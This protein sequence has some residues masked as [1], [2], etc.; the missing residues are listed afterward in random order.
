MAEGL[1]GN[2]GQA[3][4]AGFASRSFRSLI[5]QRGDAAEAELFHSDSQLE[6]DQRSSLLDWIAESAQRIAF[7]A[8]R[9]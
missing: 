8:V 1:R 2:G 4:G 5:K 6:Q 9:F 3:A 7:F